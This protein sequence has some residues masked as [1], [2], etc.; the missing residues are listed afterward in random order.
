MMVVGD[1]GKLRQILIN[2]VGNA[3]KF[4]DEGEVTL[5]VVK[6]AEGEYYFE[7]SDTG[8]G[9]AVERQ[10]AI[11]EPFHQEDEGMRQGGT[12]LGLAIARRH[13]EMMGGELVLESEVGQGSQFYFTLQLPDVAQETVDWG[14]R[15]TPEWS[16][17]KRLRKGTSILALVVDDVE[18]NRD[19]L[20]QMLKKIGVEVDSVDR[21]TAQHGKD[22]TKV[23]AV[24]ASVFDH[25]RQQ[26]MDAGFDG[27]IDKPLRAETLYSTMAELLDI[28]YEYAELEE[29]PGAP[30]SWHSLQLPEAIYNALVGAVGT[31]S[32]TELRTQVLELEALGDD[33]MP[34]AV[35]LRD[36]G[37]QYDMDC[38]AGGFRGRRRSVRWVKLEGKKRRRSFERLL[39][40]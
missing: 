17:V 14:E 13:V 37:R 3:V 31:H 28:G 34:L 35:H 38:C 19:I 25:Q 11:F 26:Y 24:T 39:F 7:V 36:L 27:F 5:R 23:V 15:E 22:A 20:S 40:L 1:E 30:K 16:N 8:A 33:Y 6:K 9:I 18:T 12:G 32:I 10:E 4:T 2:L 29:T 21:L